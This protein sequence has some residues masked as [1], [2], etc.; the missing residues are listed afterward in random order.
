MPRLHQVPL[1][2]AALTFIACTESDAP[3]ATAA[4]SRGTLFISGA[5]AGRPLLA[6]NNTEA[7]RAGSA[8]QAALAIPFDPAA[9]F[10]QTAAAAGIAPTSPAF[11]WVFAGTPHR[12]Q[13]F[14]DAAATR[15]TIYDVAAVAGQWDWTN[16]VV[17]R[18]AASW[19][20]DHDN[21]GFR[22][23][24]WREGEAHRSI[25]YDPEA[26]LE[27]AMID[28]GYYPNSLELAVPLHD[29]DTHRLIQVTIQRGERLLSSD[30]FRVYG[31][32]GG[33]VACRAFATAP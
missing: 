22:A 12:A 26:A 30:D 29:P 17:K 1:A 19:V 10:Q 11:D 5:C 25:A 3:D 28:D 21:V 8:A 4:T 27:A 33:E 9:V 2:L 16:L 15:V 31:W 7:L 13:Q 32:V 14:T 6:I 24:L 18:Y 20:P 23:Q